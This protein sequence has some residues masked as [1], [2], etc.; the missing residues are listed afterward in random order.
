MRRIPRRPP[1]LEPGVL[2][3]RP[4]PIDAPNPEKAQAFSITSTIN[5][6][7]R[8]FYKGKD[9]AAAIKGWDEAA[10]KLGE[11]AGPVIEFLKNFLPQ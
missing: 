6:V 7:Y 11:H 8:A 4:D 9:M 5:A 2:A 1:Q 10:Q 3:P